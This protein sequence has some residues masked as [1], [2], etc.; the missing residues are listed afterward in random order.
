M[1]PRLPTPEVL[2]T[3]PGGSR[4]LRVCEWPAVVS[5]ETE[6]GGAPDAP[7]RGAAAVAA[8]AVQGGSPRKAT[9]KQ[10]TLGRQLCLS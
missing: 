7:G 5:S 1:P 10:L 3:L 4:P 8:A 6:E 2:H 9:S